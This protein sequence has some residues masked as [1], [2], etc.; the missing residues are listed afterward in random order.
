MKARVKGRNRGSNSDHAVVPHT[1]PARDKASTVLSQV[2]T[3][4]NKTID[5]GLHLQA[6]QISA[7][8]RDDAS[9]VRTFLEE[10]VKDHNARAAARRAGFGPK[11]AKVTSYQVLKDNASYLAWFEAFVA[12]QTAKE[13]AIELA[14]VLQEIAKIA[15][16]NEH[17]YLTHEP[18]PTDKAKIITKRKPLN[19]LTRA[20]MVAIR[21]FHRP[22]GSLD[23]RL[24]NKE[25]RL[26]DLGK[27]LGA[28]NE[29]L[30]LEHRHAH[31]HAH[32]DLSKVPL[33]DLESIEAQL[34]RHFQVVEG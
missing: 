12:Q 8:G 32:L 15:F 7:T 28:F 21:V 4:C 1:H 17:D 25:A 30:I 33:K 5:A 16:A 24:L 27:H 6:P 26:V 19:Q 10:Y 18:D 3:T 22:D 23:Y 31:L 13:I 14:P 29:K 2:A 34:A 20:Q 9:K 11:W